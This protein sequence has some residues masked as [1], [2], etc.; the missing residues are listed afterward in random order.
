MDFFLK[1]P[2]AVTGSVC[3]RKGVQSL[4]SLPQD[5]LVFLLDC[6][7]SGDRG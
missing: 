6:L 2:W 3:G 7:I 1:C 5:E 4:S